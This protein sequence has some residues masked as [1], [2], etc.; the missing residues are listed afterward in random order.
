LSDLNGSESVR[1]LLVEDDPGDAYLVQELLE[2]GREP[3]NVTW[4]RNATSAQT[5]V[6]ESS[7]DC[8]LMDLGLP[9]SEGLGALI[10]L[11]ARSPGLP[12]VVLTGLDDRHRG[13]KALEFGAQDYLT[14][15]AVN[16]DSLIRSIRYAIVRRR[17]DD[18]A[19]RLLEAE[20]AEAENA[21]LER[22]LLARPILRDE[23]LQMASRYRPG[24]QRALLGGDFLDVVEL[25]DGTV[26][27][28]IGDVCGHGP[29][30]AALGVA[31][32]VAWRALVLA[33][34][35]PE[36][37]LAC[38][39]RVIETE[40]QNDEAF[41][42]V[43]DIEIFRDRRHARVHLAGHP[44]PVVLTGS[45]AFPVVSS[46]QGPILGVFDDP[47]WAAEVMDLGAEWTL[48]AFTDGIIERRGE[49][50]RVLEPTELADSV[51]A[52]APQVESL[53]GLAD[54]LISDAGESGGVV[55]TDD[56][57]V[58]MFSVSSRWSP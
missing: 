29:D 32:R 23:K 14:K 56:I 51:R 11:L 42:T 19:R 41:A 58:L 52:I 8:A 33:D 24:G 10:G 53:Q 38:L 26:R 34:R 27:A 1:L 37:T 40:R 31:L 55:L 2:E 4:V 48:V 54:R 16:A 12:V 7:F 18:A 15:A 6:A 43:C 13:E 5:A 9:D 57:A 50:G 49:S 21:R 39:H 45:D 28:V 47:S 30:E 25:E 20:L 3:I 35:G 17:S 22:G 46:N 36:D 44:S